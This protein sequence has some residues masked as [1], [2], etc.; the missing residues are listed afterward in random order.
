MIGAAFTVSSKPATEN[1][2]AKYIRG[3]LEGHEPVSRRLLTIAAT[4]SRAPPMAS[5]G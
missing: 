3:A 1:A 2:K 4:I 5:I